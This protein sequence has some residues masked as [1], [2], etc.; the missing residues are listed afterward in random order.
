[1]YHKG[2]ALVGTVTGSVIGGGSYLLLVPN[3]LFASSLVVLY[4]TG[5]FLMIDHIRVLRT[6]GD[7]GGSWWAMAFGGMLGLALIVM[8]E[9][10]MPVAVLAEGSIEMPTGAVASLSVEFTLLLYLFVVSIALVSLNI[11][12]RM[13]RADFADE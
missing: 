7:S 2:S 12:F 11:G 3:L 9:V 1:M 8:Q 10:Y 13:A 6:E 4:S 5:V